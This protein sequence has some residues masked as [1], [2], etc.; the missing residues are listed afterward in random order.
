MTATPTLPGL[1]SRRL[2]NLIIAA[3]ERCGLDLS[4][5]VVL[6][7]AATGAY[8]ST[9]LLAAVGGASRVYAIARPS[10]FGAVGEIMDQM[11]AAARWVGVSRIIEVITEK[12][13]EVLARAD[14]VTNSG[15]VRPIDA[16]TIVSMKPTAVVPLMYE[17]WEFREQDVDLVACR[18]RGISV[19]GTN[20]RHPAV[21]VFSYL[22][23]MA[24]KLL[25]DA[26]VAVY[27]SR[28]LVLCDN[29]FEADVC[30]GL[31]AAGASVDVVSELG[32]AGERQGTDAVLVALQPRGEPLLGGREARFIAGH[33]P[34]AVVCQFWG[35][36]DRAELDAAGVA[37]W[38]VRPPGLGHMGVLPSDVGP[39]P[40]VRLQAGGLKVAEI[41]LRAGRADCV[42]DW[43]Y[44]YEI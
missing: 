34:G 9:A 7:E 19:A 39:E 16:A 8:A 3:V 14:V 4:G 2:A 35:D 40:V 22:G 37:Y 31:T 29:P 24:V 10:R 11:T 20:E 26:G 30:K 13:P 5:A 42:H 15:H 38:P 6:T 44:V 18:R 25:L 33:F 12:T 41:L 17:S 27:G 1:N 43:D 21:N 36:F 23:I 32:Q 28:I